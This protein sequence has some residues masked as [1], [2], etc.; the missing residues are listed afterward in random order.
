MSYKTLRPQ[1]GNLIDSLD[2]IHEVSDTPALKFGGFPAVHIVPSD[3]ESDYETTTENE[4]VY[5]FLVRV[6]YETK[7]TGVAEAIDKLEDAVDD[8]IDAI[9][10]EDKKGSSTRTVG[11]DLPSDYIYLAVSATPSVWGQIDEEQLVFAEIRVRV[12]VSFDAS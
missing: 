4:R 10:R 1:L 8:I 5:A 6:F 2:K 3:S 9:D 11:I 7:Q 12:R